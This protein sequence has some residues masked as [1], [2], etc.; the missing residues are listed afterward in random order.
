[1]MKEKD[2]YVNDKNLILLYLRTTACFAMTVRMT[3][4][5]NLNSFQ[6]PP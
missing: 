3:S 4:K 2:L 1:M 5:R 6:M